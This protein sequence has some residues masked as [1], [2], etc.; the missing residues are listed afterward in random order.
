MCPLCL[1]CPQC[2]PSALVIL[3]L[4]GLVVAL[5]GAAFAAWGWASE[6]AINVK[7]RRALAIESE[8]YKQ[9]VQVR[10]TEGSTGAPFKRTTGRFQR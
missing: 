7:L 5:L 2:P 4:A 3:L 9:L 1:H 10:F 8:S 6:R